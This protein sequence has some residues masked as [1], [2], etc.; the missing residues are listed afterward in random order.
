[1][2]QEA[3]FFQVYEN[4]TADNAVDFLEQCKAFFPLRCNSYF[5]RQWARF[6]DRFARGNN[7]PSGNH[8]FDK[9]SKKEGINHRLTAPATPKSNGMVER[10]NGT[11]KVNSYNKNRKQ[12]SLVK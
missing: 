9:A 8:K 4:K 12:G 10:V 2:Q 3:C 6:T 7:T 1:M 5:D 11:I